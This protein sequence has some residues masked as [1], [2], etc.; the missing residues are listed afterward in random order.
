M[1]IREDLNTF[2]CGIPSVWRVSFQ[3]GEFSPE[4]CCLGQCLSVNTILHATDDMFSES[5][6]YSTLIQLTTNPD[7]K[8]R[9][10]MLIDPTLRRK[11]RSSRAGAGPL[12]SALSFQVSLSLRWLSLP[13]PM[14]LLEELGG[15][16]RDESCN[17][18]Y[19][20][21]VD[22]AAS[23]SFCPGSTCALLLEQGE[24]NNYQICRCPL[25]LPPGDT[26]DWKGLL[27]HSSQNKTWANCS[28]FFMPCNKKLGL[29][30]HNF[31]T[32]APLLFKLSGLPAM[33]GLNSQRF[34]AGKY[35]LSL[36]VCR[37]LIVKLNDWLSGCQHLGK[38]L[39]G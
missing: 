7:L 5:P 27:S 26:P 25:A 24:Q 6:Q 19:W 10:S 8:G 18:N 1:N 33:R 28:P 23:M 4:G 15:Q 39:R 32:F 37:G 35:S 31:P 38:A 21:H 3:T 11:V 2:L 14:G 34:I 30:P 29:G 9:L 12:A 36:Y 17:R 22:E 20:M 13:I 16:C